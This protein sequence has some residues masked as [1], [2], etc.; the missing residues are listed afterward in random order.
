MMAKMQDQPSAQTLIH[1]FG[2]GKEQH[3]LETQASSTLLK[4][5]HHEQVIACRRVKG[6]A[7]RITAKP[8]GTKRTTFFV[9]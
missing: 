5:S 8:E 9:F 2:R 4:Y 3:D 1:C 7:S 6:V